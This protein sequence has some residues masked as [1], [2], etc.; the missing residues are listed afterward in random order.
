MDS[1]SGGG[2]KGEDSAKPAVVKWAF[3]VDDNLWAHSSPAQAI[4]GLGPLKAAGGFNS[5]I[6]ICAPDRPFRSRYRSG[7]RV[8]VASGIKSKAIARRA[9]HQKMLALERIVLYIPV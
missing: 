1:T 9:I 5:P 6:A 2:L 8:K 7:M 4:D 3:I